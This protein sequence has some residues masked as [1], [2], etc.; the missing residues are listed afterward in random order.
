MKETHRLSAY[1]HGALREVF[2]G[3]R[4]LREAVFGLGFPE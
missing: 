1:F 2:K 3:R 4:E